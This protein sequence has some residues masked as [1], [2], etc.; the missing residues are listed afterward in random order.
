MF[1]CD[2]CSWWCEAHER[3]FNDYDV[4]RDC[5]GDEDNKFIIALMISAVSFGSLASTK[6]SMKM[7]ML[8][9]NRTALLPSMVKFVMLRNVMVK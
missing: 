9:S 2:S 7:V 8:K 4:C 5:S 1:L 6:V 3:S